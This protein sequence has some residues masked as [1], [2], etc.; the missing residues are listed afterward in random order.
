MLPIFHTQITSSS[1][2]LLVLGIEILFQLFSSAMSSDFF[3]DD[4]NLFDDTFLE[5]EVHSHG[6]NVGLEVEAFKFTR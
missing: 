2:R 1:T 6:V 3:D 4:D 5:A